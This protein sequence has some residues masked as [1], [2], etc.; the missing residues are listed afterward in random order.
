MHNAAFGDHMRRWGQLTGGVAEHA[1]GAAFLQPAQESLIRARAEAWEA[2][3]RQL[4]HR[5]AA[6][7][8]TRDLE[9]DAAALSR[10]TATA[11]GEAPRAEEEAAARGGTAPP[12]AEIAPTHV[13]GVASAGCLTPGT[14]GGY[15][16][17]SAV[18]RAG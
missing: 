12:A 18:A 7:Q 11:G 6:Q 2:K 4:R 3:Q 9:A 14:F 8:A 1:A 5:A 13:V 10:A 16:F 15:S 17:L